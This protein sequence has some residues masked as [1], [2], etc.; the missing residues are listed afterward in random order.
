MTNIGDYIKLIEF[1]GEEILLPLFLD[2]QSTTPLAPE[3]E[4]ALFNA[5]EHPGNPQSKDHIFGLNAAHL[6]EKSR[7]DVANLIGAKPDEI[8]FTSG[9]TE[10]NDI[11]LK[12]FLSNRQ[13]PA[14]II[15]CVTEH[16]SILNLLSFY[17]E[18][19]H[20][21]T[22]L[23]VDPTGRVCL[24]KLKEAIRPETALVTLQAANNEIGTLQDILAIDEICALNEI[25]FHSDCVQLL[26]SNK[27][28]VSTLK[29]KAASLSAHKLYGPQGIGALYVRRGVEIPK[30]VRPS[31]TQ[32]AAL[33]AAFGAAASLISHSSAADN[34]ELHQLSK[35][36]K[37]HLIDKLG[38]AIRFNGYP[39]MTLPGCLSITFKHVS[40]ED[41]LAA[42]PMLALSTGSACLSHDG[43]PSHVLKAIGLTPSECDRTIRIGLGRYV[44]ET[45][46]R[47]AAS[48]IAN[49]CQKLGT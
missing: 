18:E 1:E 13:A 12:L 38:D 3:A 47:Y 25:P 24:Q 48:M 21:V 27:L 8:L 4:L 28:D 10:A 20:R 44:T 36:L 11:A 23:P 42:L 34:A 22:L 33:A 7:Q 26:A 17:Q 5:L 9:A 35:T 45:E 31:G 32:S 2:H 30:R 37:N 46:V 43:K 6:I 49:A 16:H 14:H 39:K 19:G 29:I 41:L 40:A 15:S